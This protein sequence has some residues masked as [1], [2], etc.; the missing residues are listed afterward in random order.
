MDKIETVIKGR[1]R[2]GLGQG[3]YFTQLDW[4]RR[5][6]RDK[7]GFEPWPGTL[8]I[9]VD[10]A[11]REAAAELRLE[12]GVEIVPPSADNCPARAV[13]VTI[14]G[15]AAAVILPEAAAH[16][17]T[18]HGEEILE[19]IAPVKLKDVLRISEGDAVT[20]TCRPERK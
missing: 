19:I 18:V 15:Q 20:V 6:C 10:A 16:T 3:A 2:E 5:Q 4:V 17:D 7:L 8:N 11:G 13:P 9:E 12:K 14:D 1:L